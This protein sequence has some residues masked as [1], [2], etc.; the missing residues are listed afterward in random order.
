VNEPETNIG[1]RV[2]TMQVIAGALITGVL[3]FAAITVILGAW[4]Q[5]EQEGVIK[6]VGIGLILAETIPFVIVPQIITPDRLAQ[7]FENQSRR[8]N[9]VDLLLQTYQ[10]RMIVRF[11]LVEGAAFLNLIAFM[12]EHAKW[13]LAIAGGLV[14]VM[15]V[16]FPTRTKVAHWLEAEQVRGD[17]S[18]NS[19]SR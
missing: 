17:V 4:N 9:P 13:S 15:L 6:Y 5:P 16:I 3:L 14:L 19:D 11:A 12:T 2:R 18:S 1:P 8:L 10:T 7:T